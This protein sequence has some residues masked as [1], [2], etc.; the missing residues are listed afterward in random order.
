M[1]YKMPLW[2]RMDNIIWTLNLLDKTANIVLGQVCYHQ[3]KEINRR[4]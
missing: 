4:E 3:A 1:E 2:L